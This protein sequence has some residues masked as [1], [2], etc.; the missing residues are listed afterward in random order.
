[1]KSDVKNLLLNTKGRD[2]VEWAYRDMPVLQ[3]VNSVLSRNKPLKNINLAA[4]LHITT[5]TAN[6]LITLKNAGAKVAC[7][8]S[9]PLST[10]DD[11]GSCQVQKTINI[12]L[13]FPDWQEISPF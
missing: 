7:C 1:M 3:E 10:Q 8:A 9:N 6:L 13:P 11:A 12:T 5:E 2:R 4:C